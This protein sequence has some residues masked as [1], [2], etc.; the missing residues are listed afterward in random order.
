MIIGIDFGT[1]GLCFAYGRLNDIFKQVTTGYFDGQIE[2]NKISNEII[3]DDELKRVLA[4]GKD[5]INFLCSNHESKFHHFKHIKMNL[6]KKQ[7]K[8][9]ASNSGIE[10][11][12]VDI[13]K[14]ILIEA[15]KKQ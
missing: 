2:N 1:S 11:D 15:K 13:I 4:F 5:C 3:L 6:Y 12:I 7:Y 10:V 9:K 8:I 14:L